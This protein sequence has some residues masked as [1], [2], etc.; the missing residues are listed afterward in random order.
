MHFPSLIFSTLFSS[1]LED[2]VKTFESKCEISHD[3]VNV[4]LYESF[5]PLEAL[6]FEIG[7]SHMSKSETLNIVKLVLEAK[8]LIVQKPENVSKFFNISDINNEKGAIKD[9]LMKRQS[10]ISSDK[11]MI[12]ES[13]VKDKLHSILDCIDKLKDRI[14]QDP[15][16]DKLYTA[17]VERIYNSIYEN[18]D[19]QDIIEKEKNEFYREFKNFT[20]KKIK[21][22]KISL[23]LGST[24]VNLPDLLNFSIRLKS[25][26]RENLI[27]EWT[28]GIFDSIENLLTQINSKDFI[29][30][31][32]LVEKFIKEI[33]GSEVSNTA[34]EVR[35]SI[36]K[37][38]DMQPDEID[39]FMTR[40][41]KINF[42]ILEV[43][44]NLK[45]P[46]WII[47]Y[48]KEVKEDMIEYLL[49]LQPEDKKKVLSH[50]Q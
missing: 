40:Q 22:S 11:S 36:I 19:L 4:I 44:Q 38:L 3:I 23:S 37:A 15:K 6:I 41:K 17:M 12:F 2:P 39:S 16:I 26:N 45:T 28:K 48:N 31:K 20:P 21:E 8:K 14:V 32:S 10:L 50:F 49:T 27:R 43:I 46:Q 25:K 42:S 5:I 13:L 1:L 34:Y 33:A 9:L 47:K 18:M 35:T 29:E 7:T 30:Q 24:I